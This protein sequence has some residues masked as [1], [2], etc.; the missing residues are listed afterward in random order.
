MAQNIRLQIKNVQ[1]DLVKG[2]SQQ[3]GEAAFA[4]YSAIII[5]SPVDT[6]HFRHNWQVGLNS[7]PAGIKEGT[8][9]SGQKNISQNRSGF[10][11]YQMGTGTRANII[12]F[13]NNVPYALKL[14]E[15]HS[16][17]APSG[18][19]QRALRAGINAIGT[20]GKIFKS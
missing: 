5:A 13:T 1:K 11:N 12:F 7:R 15:G 20:T 3:I 17:Q 8:D 18:F 10:A 2:I 4:A 9:R 19:V 16:Q 14:N 6:G